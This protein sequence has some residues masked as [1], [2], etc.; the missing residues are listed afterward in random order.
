MKQRHAGDV[1][2]DVK[3]KPPALNQNTTTD[4]GPTYQVFLPP[5]RYDANQK[6]QQPPDPGFIVLVRR[7]RVR[8]T[9]IFQGRVEGEPLVAENLP[10][11]VAAPKQNTEQS[12]QAKSPA[13]NPTVVNR[14]RTF[15]KRLWNSNS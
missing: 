8:P 15:F 14:V 10:V 5:M 7:A 6:V 4:E 1:N 9:L 2:S 12:T 11:P 3:P 13:S